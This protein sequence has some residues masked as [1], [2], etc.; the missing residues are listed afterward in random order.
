MRRLRPEDGTP[1]HRRAAGYHIT[2][3]KQGKA[4][5]FGQLAAEMTAHRTALRSKSRA[6]EDAD[7]ALIEASAVAD[8]TEIDFEDTVRDIDTELARLDRK[9]ISLGAQ[10]A[11]F[12]NGFGEVIDPEGS[13]QLK[14]IPALELRLAPF[15]NLP[16][17]APLMTQL[18][19]S[20]SA[21]DQALKAEE[22]ASAAYD[23]A[24]LQEQDARRAIR[25][26]FESAY[27]RLRDL[28]KSR[29]AMAERF[30]SR[31]GSARQ[32]V[33]EKDQK[34]PPTPTAGAPKDGGVGTRDGKP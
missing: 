16:T 4:P 7:D 1:A 14:V 11:V 13:E 18:A 5:L 25:E 17:V 27:G 23:F 15:A 21:F 24:F 26:Q 19:A 33:K 12:S 34:A 29:P 22:A 10:K 3:C 28:F 32:P 8:A 6:V 31:E 2:K 20:V 30:F 9:D